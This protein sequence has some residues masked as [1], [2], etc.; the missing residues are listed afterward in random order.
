M[1]DRTAASPSPS[2]SRPRTPRSHLAPLPA[3]ALVVLAASGLATPA[4]AV[5]HRAVSLQFS[6]G[7][8]GTAWLWN[9]PGLVTVDLQ[10]P[11]T[12]H[13]VRELAVRPDQPFAGGWERMAGVLADRNFDDPYSGVMRW[14][15]LDFATRHSSASEPFCT[16][17]C[18][19]PIPR[20]A[21]GEVFVLAGVR[22]AVH[23]SSDIRIAEIAVQPNPALGYV[24]VTFVDN[25][26]TRPYFAQVDWAYVPAANVATDG[27]NA[28]GSSAGS[29]FIAGSRKALQG[30]RVAFV[31]GDR[32]LRRFTI[33]LDQGVR[34]RLVDSDGAERIAWAVDWVVLTD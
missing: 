21:A 8:T 6:S 4:A 7:A 3:L 20:A 33:D 11:N 30:F 25:S 19:L 28:S 32:A 14:A 13:N 29:A 12:E 18:R 17:T 2:P 1:S 23:N 9:V 26:R 31:D 24:D 34:V 5:V 10:Y 27:F 22:F 16:G 15:Q